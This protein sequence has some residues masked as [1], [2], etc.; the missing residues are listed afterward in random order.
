[1]KNSTNCL[2]L[3]LTT[4]TSEDKSKHSSAIN[5]HHNK[6]SIPLNFQNIQTRNSLE[7]MD[8]SKNNH[9]KSKTQNFCNT[10]DEKMFMLSLQSAFFEMPTTPLTIEKYVSMQ[11]FASYFIFVCFVNISLMLLYCNTSSKSPRLIL[12]KVSFACKSHRCY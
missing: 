1:M 12:G 8:L 3:A 11:K 4:T 9:T 7:N 6:K 10:M 2:Q 5:V